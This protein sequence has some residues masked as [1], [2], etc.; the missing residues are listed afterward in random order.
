MLAPNTRLKPWGK[1]RSP[2]LTSPIVVMVVALDDCTRRVMI[3]PQNV[4]SRGVA[5]AFS[6][7]VFNAVPA[8]ALS[9]SVITAMPSRNRPTPPTIETV[10]SNFPPGPCVIPQWES[11]WIARGDALVERMRR[12]TWLVAIL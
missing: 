3:A 9:P 6:N 4:P 12:G 5:A 10:V 8:R 7:T 1:V 2:A 11:T